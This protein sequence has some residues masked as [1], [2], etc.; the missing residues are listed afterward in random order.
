M[1]LL[2]GD[3]QLDDSDRSSSSYEPAYDSRKNVLND[4]FGSQLATQ[5]RCKQY[6]VKCGFQI[7]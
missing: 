6:A 2:R 5:L 7:S 3:V 1:D 4:T